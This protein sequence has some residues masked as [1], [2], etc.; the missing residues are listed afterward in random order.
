MSVGITTFGI[1]FLLIV[2]IWIFFWSKHLIPLLI[3]S[4]IFQAASIYNFNSFAVAPYYFISII[5]ALNFLS[6]TIIFN[7]KLYIANRNLRYSVVA[8]VVFFGWAMVSS[9]TLPFIF[10]GMPVFS[11]KDG[12]DE[13]YFYQAKLL[14]STSNVAQAVYLLL[15]I[16]N[17]IVL[18]QYVSNKRNKDIAM[19]SFLITAYIAIFMILYHSL[20]KFVQIPFPED[21][22]YSNPFYSQGF[23]QRVGNLFRANGT[24]SE[25]SLAGTYIVGIACSFFAIRINNN[26]LIQQFLIFTISFLALIVTTA[27][28]GYAT[29]FIIICALIIIK[30]FNM[31]RFKLKKTTLIKIILV[32]FFIGLILIVLV[33]SNLLS[34]VEALTTSKGESD[35][36]K[37]R[38]FSDLFAINIFFETYGLGVGLGSNRPSSYLTSLLSNLGIIGTGIMAYVL[39]II[40]KLTFKY[41]QNDEIKFFFLIFISTLVSQVL[42]IPDITMPFF[43]LNL[44]YLLAYLNYISLKL[45]TKKDINRSY[46]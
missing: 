36:F 12:I 31:Y 37:H 11:P 21:F 22:L 27:T 8:L 4:S 42:S 13:Q 18:I 46:S 16:I 6:T 19:N 28:T 32:S 39:L 26:T 23:E 17:V 45:A 2:S 41:R 38:M 34:A 43:W 20:S 33:N 44:G 10:E 5:V 25:P 24:F 14:W 29:F 40:S 3:F 1:F 15:N 35:S 7:R 30:L 9:I